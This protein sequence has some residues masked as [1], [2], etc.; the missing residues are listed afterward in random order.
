MAK[1]VNQPTRFVGASTP[2]E[3]AR[4]VNFGKRL[5]AILAEKEMT[6]S[7]V[8]AKIWSRQRNAKGALVAKGRDRLSVWINGKSFPDHENRLKLAKALGMPVSELFPDDELQTAN[9]ATP[10]GSIVWSK[11][12][13]AGQTFLQLAQF[14]SM[15]AALEILA[16]IKR[17]EQ[18]GDTDAQT[19][20]DQR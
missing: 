17:D 3:R 15:E 10:E 18:K 13:P 1:M 6:A 20:V 11:D 16:I 19:A 4:D 5:K 2:L 14:V 7:D 12:Y 8:A 9:R